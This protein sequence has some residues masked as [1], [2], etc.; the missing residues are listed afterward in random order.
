M[1][2]TPPL[3]PQQP[4]QP[5]PLDFLPPIP[6]IYYPYFV[7]FYI[8]YV[9]LVL[10]PSAL[11]VPT[12]VLG[13]VTAGAARDIMDELGVTNIQ[14]LL[15]EASNRAIST[16]REMLRTN[17]IPMVRT[18][19]LPRIRDLVASL[20]PGILDL[21]IHEFMMSGAFMR[22]YGFL[23][24][25]MAGLEREDI[26]SILANGM[27]ERERNM[28]L[29][30]GGIGRMIGWN[31]FEGMLDSIAG[32]TGG[33]GAALLEG[34]S[35][36]PGG[37]LHFYDEGNNRYDDADQSAIPSTPTGSRA[38]STSSVSAST[39]V[40]MPTGEPS[41]TP[42]ST[43]HLTL[44]TPP[45]TDDLGMPP[46]DVLTRHVAPILLP[47]AR[48]AAAQAVESMVNTAAAYADDFM[49]GMEGSVFMFGAG[50]ITLG[51]IGIGLGNFGGVIGARLGEVAM[52][53][54]RPIIRGY[55][56]WI[57][58]GVRGREGRVGGGVGAV[59][60]G[61]GVVV[62]WGGIRRNVKN[63][64]KKD[65]CAGDSSGDR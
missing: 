61:A 8:S 42:P 56:R 20:R 57:A 39:P 4:T 29:E 40:A 16:T 12:G 38:A 3:K 55:V 11:L 49:E 54:T 59:M 19:V 35:P 58:E 32:V 45:T 53:I 65:D 51:G 43:D 14:G 2:K 9:T 1:S 30:G 48:E 50:F 37:D 34:S 26:E 10:L 13:L 60:L 25:Y 31:N 22:R 18:N 7:L 5:T 15:T 24:I 23:A 64:R 27:G 28:V 52:R 41:S 44:P 33:D 63:R 62:G 46:G 17:L 21:S 6:Y 47:R 36:S